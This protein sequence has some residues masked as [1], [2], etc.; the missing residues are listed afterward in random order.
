MFKN[1]LLNSG[2]N[3]D[4]PLTNSRVQFFPTRR[5][6]ERRHDNA[7]R[8]TSHGP[9]TGRPGRRRVQPPERH[10][11]RRGLHVPR[12]LRQRHRQ[13]KRRPALPPEGRRPVHHPRPHPDGGDQPVWLRR[14]RHA[15][16]WQVG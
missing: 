14:R 13:L 7:G 5:N 1:F 3:S 9:A 11:R 6:R 10:K 12:Q 4:A 2:R 15:D 8:D 16:G